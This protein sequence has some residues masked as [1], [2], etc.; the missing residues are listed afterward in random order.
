MGT[1]LT[2]AEAAILAS[3]NANLWRPWVARVDAE[4]L[5]ETALGRS[6]AAAQGGEVVPAPA[7]ARFRR[8]VARRVAGEPI[9]LLRGGVEFRGLHLEV[10]KGT[11]AP[12][13][14]TEALAGEAIRR[15]RRRPGPVA[16]DVATGV[17]PVAL[18][19][20]HEVPQA[21]VHGIDIS[22]R[23]ITVARAN[24]RRLELANVAFHC[25]D[26][27]GG[28]PRRLR[29]RIDVLTVHPPYVPQLEVRDLPREIS[30]YEPRHTL[31]DGSIDGLGLV[32]TLATD[33]SEWLRRGGWLL[34]EV[35]PDRAR[36]VRSILRRAGLVDV[37]S[38]RPTLPVTR[39]VVG[40]T[41]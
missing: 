35:S 41:H 10:R 26:G 20:G 39:V 16:V 22:K 18:A 7:A 24:A 27:L 31:T 9:A 34:V 2:D 3:P 8:L 25:G 1:L 11:F 32:R 14:S 36:S 12:R 30:V 38:L 19:V 13:L 6:G 33:A 23:A 15:L 17:G 4:E 5:L 29:G 40:R 28:L 21:D 37:R